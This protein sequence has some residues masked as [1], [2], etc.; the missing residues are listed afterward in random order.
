MGHGWMLYCSLHSN[1]ISCLQLLE[2][3][4]NDGGHA[5]VLFFIPYLSLT[6]N[7][8]KPIDSV[9]VMGKLMFISIIGVVSWEI[10]LISRFWTWLFVVVW[11]LSY[12][13][14]FP[15]LLALGALFE[16]IGYY[17]SS[18]VRHF[19]QLPHVCATPKAYAR[20]AALGSPLHPQTLPDSRFAPVDLQAC[21]VR[22]S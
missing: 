1:P 11:L 9:Y 3:K 5:Q 8:P 18:H 10:G 16:R 21:C 15:F 2:L 6:T 20:P 19:L 12:F 17:D 4:M 22:R 7:G 13:V 14:T